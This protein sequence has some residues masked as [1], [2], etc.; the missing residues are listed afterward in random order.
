MRSF[1]LMLV[2]LLFVPQTLNADGSAS[3]SEV[4]QALHKSNPKLVEAVRAAFDLDK[5]AEASRI[6]NAINQGWT[7]SGSAPTG[8]V[9]ASKDLS[10]R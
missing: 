8:C 9:L 10:A 5:D 6:G 1:A 4:L 7:D 3:T 2:L